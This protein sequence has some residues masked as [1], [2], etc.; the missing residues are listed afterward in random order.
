MSVNFPTSLD[1]LQ[2]PTATDYLNSP[3]HSAQHANAND[4]LEALEA[5]V[6]ITGV[7]FNPAS[8]SA[9][10]SLDLHEDTDNGT[11]K[12][13]I[14]APSAIASDK[15]LT[16]PDATDT[17]VGKATTD[18][19][20]NKVLSTGV[21]LDANADAN[22]T[23]YGMARQAITNGNFDVWQRGTSVAVADQVIT[24]QA[25]RWREYV[26]KN[27]GTLPTLTR[28]RQLHT[29]GDIANSFYFSRLATNGAGTSLGV[30]SIGLFAQRIENGT[31]NLC[32]LNKKVTV[33]FWAKSNIANKRSCPNLSQNYG[34]GGSPTAV[35]YILGTPITLTS[36]WTKYTATFTTNTLVGKTFGTAGD[37]YLSLNFWYMWGTT[38]GNTLVQA[39]VTAETFVGAG[40]IDIA[41]VQL[42]SG[43]VALPFQPKSYEE[44]LRA[45]Q[46]YYEKSFQYADAPQVAKDGYI[47]NS[48]SST[49]N[50][51][52][53]IPFKV[54]KRTTPTITTW[55]D[56]A[57]STNDAAA[58]YVIEGVNNYTDGV[59]SGKNDVKFS[60]KFAT[61]NAGNKRG[62]WEASAEL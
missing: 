40:N 36:T 58:N 4:I 29:S 7:G 51:I 35:E 2:N 28:S 57:S 52:L 54:T 24:F 5:K 12:I 25:D 10:A 16:L 55:N 20:T 31:R 62:S 45:C 61:G 15:V 49:A 59:I 27:G 21:S 38:T 43:D 34:T 3:S 30:S 47:F 50:Q 37:D 18:T 42:C 44:E 13:T 46:R 6:G 8:T 56:A 14:T 32:G 1:V 60:I 53:T 17:L 48:G 22:I 19:L 33:S 11:N 39:S 9:P 41:Q 26:D 23:Q